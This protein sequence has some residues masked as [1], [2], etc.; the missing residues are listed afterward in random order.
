MFPSLFNNPPLAYLLLIKSQIITA[1]NYSSLPT[2]KNLTVSLIV[3]ST[4]S[5]FNAIEEM[6]IIQ[7]PI[8]LGVIISDNKFLNVKCV[9][10]SPVIKNA[11]L[12][13][14]KRKSKK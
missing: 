11:Q 1:E 2:Y 8:L 10:D 7:S 13:V 12:N 5:D 4:F 14:I 6:P 9:G 3:D